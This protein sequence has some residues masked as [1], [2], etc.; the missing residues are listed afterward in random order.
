M[1]IK[2]KIYNP[3]TPC[4]WFAVDSAH[5]DEPVCN[6]FGYMKHH[7]HCNNCPNKETIDSKNVVIDIADEELKRIIELSKGGKNDK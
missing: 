1:K 3:E 7:A 4:K 5:W 2:A 6:K